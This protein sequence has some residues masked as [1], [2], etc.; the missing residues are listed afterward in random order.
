MEIK[1]VKLDVPEGMNI[2]LGQSHFIKTVEDLYESIVN[3]VPQARFGLAFAEASGD[4]LIRYAGNDQDLEKMACE[5]MMDIGAGHSFLIYL[6]DAFPINII[7]RIKDIP[8]V[9][10]I[11]C[12]TANPVE[13]LIVESEQGRGIIGVIDGSIPQGIESEEDI[14][15][16][17]KFLRDIGYKF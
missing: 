16:R 17:R 7:Q 5:K 3:T 9:V 10:N 2:I 14:L 1:K 12:A 6:K 13:I 8:E 15:N 4:C 11:F